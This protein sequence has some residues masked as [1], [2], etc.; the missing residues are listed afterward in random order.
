MKTVMRVVSLSCVSRHL[1]GWRGATQSNK[2]SA[3]YLCSQ[4]DNFNV[5][6]FMLL[7]LSLSPYHQPTATVV[8]LLR[9]CCITGIAVLTVTL[10]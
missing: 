2:S 4:M 8:L 3:N 1:W 5:R 9:Y 10:L 7:F 6:I